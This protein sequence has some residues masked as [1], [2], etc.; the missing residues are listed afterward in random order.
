M[1]HQAREEKDIVVSDDVWL[2]AGVIVTGGVELAEGIVVAAGAVVT[3][4]V[5][6][7]YSIIGGIPARIIGSRGDI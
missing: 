2:G 5:D 4:G 6:E 1:T 7:P 3:R